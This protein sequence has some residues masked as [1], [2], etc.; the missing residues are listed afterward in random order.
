MTNVKISHEPSEQ[1]TVHHRLQG[2]QRIHR[3]YG[4]WILSTG[5]GG[6]SRTR[7]RYEYF[8]RY[9]EFYCI[10]HMFDGRGGFWMPGGRPVAVEPG[11]GIIVT[12]QQV[13]HYG[14][15]EKDYCEDTICFFGPIAD[16]LLR[17]GIIR[18]GVLEVGLTRRLLPIIDLAA[19]PAID[20]QLGANV[21]LQQLLLDLFQ[22]NRRRQPGQQHHRL[23]ELLAI[24]RATPEKWWTVEEMAEYC[25][26]SVAQFRRVFVG[27]TG[28]LPKLY[29]DRLKTTLAGERLISTT[30]AVEEIAAQLGYRDPFH[31]SRRFKQMTGFSPEKYRAENPHYR[32][33]GIADGIKASD[34]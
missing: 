3:E 18:N 19:D 24:I 33:P 34:D 26:L 14:A 1:C 5:R 25:N 31:F 17:N 32:A 22:E 11:Q 16:L 9:F 10:S 28:I 12:P 21:A 20:A 8:S 30:Y 13:H 23:E 6:V 15:A 29:L 4:L 27:H 7:G 2:E